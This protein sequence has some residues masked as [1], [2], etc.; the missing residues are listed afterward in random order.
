[1][2]LLKKHL[3][4]SKLLPYTN[5]NRGLHYDL[6]KHFQCFFFLLLRRMI[7]PCLSH[8]PTFQC[9]TQFNRICWNLYEQCR[10]FLFISS[11][12]Y[13]CPSFLL[14]F[15]ITFFLSLLLSF[16]LFFVIVRKPITYSQIMF[17]C[18]QF[19]HV[20]IQQYYTDFFKKSIAQNKL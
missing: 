15:F 16:F 18:K 5:Q 2:I 17:V 8:F 6:S 9:S 19:L 3:R 4:F 7:F 11:I 1:M 10:S 14:W 13:F 20:N 12:I